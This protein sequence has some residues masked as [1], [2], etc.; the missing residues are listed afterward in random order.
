[1]STRSRSAGHQRGERRR[2]A[3]VVVEQVD[4]GGQRFENLD[5]LVRRALAGERDAVGQQAPHGIGH[6]RPDMP[7]VVVVVQVT[8]QQR[9]HPQ[10]RARRQPFQTAGDRSRRVRIARHDFQQ[11][12]FRRQHGFDHP[13]PQVFGTLQVADGKREPTLPPALIGGLEETDGLQNPGAGRRAARAGGASS[14][15]P[16]AWRYAFFE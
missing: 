4:L 1:M 13:A 3:P 14:S 6:F 2:D 12:P 9:E 10:L 8:Q 7:H 5:D 11:Q 16:S 15:A